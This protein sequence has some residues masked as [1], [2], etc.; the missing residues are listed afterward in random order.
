M[1]YSSSKNTFMKNTTGYKK[2]GEV[3]I[4]GAASNEQQK[5]PLIPL[6]KFLT[7]AEMSDRGAKGLCYF[8]DEKFTPAH[9]LT[10]KKAQLYLLDV[11][12]EEEDNAEVRAILEQEEE[13]DIAHISFSAIAG[14]SDYATMKV[15]GFYGKRPVF[16]LI[17]LVLHTTSWTREL[18]R[19]WD[20]IS[21]LQVL[22]E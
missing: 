2:E 5:S 10:H 6:R 9:N 1:P 16:V 15:K 22:L 13:C 19:S 11:N 14:I 3:K 4:G 7:P 21:N 17:D 12:E 18:Q 8:C 20:A